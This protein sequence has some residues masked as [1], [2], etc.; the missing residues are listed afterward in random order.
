MVAKIILTLC[1]LLPLASSM[2]LAGELNLTQQGIDKQYEI[3]SKEREYRRWI[4]WRNKYN[5]EMRELKKQNDRF[6][7]HA[8]LSTVHC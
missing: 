7:W 4:Q 3:E 8:P 5:R 2:S 6:Y 1:L